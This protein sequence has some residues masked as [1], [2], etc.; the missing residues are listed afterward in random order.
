MYYLFIYFTETTP[1]NK[2][3]FSAQD[4]LQ[5]LEEQVERMKRLK[6]YE[7]IEN[8][9]DRDKAEMELVKW[10]YES[11]ST[12]STITKQFALEIFTNALVHC[13]I[14]NLGSELSQMLSKETVP[15]NEMYS[16]LASSPH[17][18]KY[19]SSQNKKSIEKIK[20]LCFSSASNAVKRFES[21]H[22]S[23]MQILENLES[24]TQ[25]L[26]DKKR[27]Q[28]AVSILFVFYNNYY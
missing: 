17:F 8:T 25:D 21:S 5:C 13:R 27:N 23:A 18:K 11:P 16:T 24:V 3:P 14:S 15:M 10:K 12:A 1:V 2:I 19:L 20:R 6:S 7:E 22:K 26:I 4:A 28:S 9:G